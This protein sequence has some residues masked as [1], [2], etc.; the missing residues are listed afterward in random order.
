MTTDINNADSIG[1]AQIR[2]AFNYLPRD[3]QGDLINEIKAY[4]NN[5]VLEDDAGRVRFATFRSLDKVCAFISMNEDI[6]KSQIYPALRL[7]GYNDRYRNYKAGNPDLLVQMGK[8]VRL[9]ILTANHHVMNRVIDDNDIFETDKTIVFRVAKPSIAVAAKNA[10]KYGIRVSELNLFNVL[11]GFELLMSNEPNY[12]L[13]ADSKIFRR[14]H[15]LFF[16]LKES[17]AWKSSMMEAMLS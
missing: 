10:D 9:C 12:I 2:P 16:D 15:E 6:P 8:L 5:K 1:D 14:T 4:S 7:I 13:L 17:I 3:A 11:R